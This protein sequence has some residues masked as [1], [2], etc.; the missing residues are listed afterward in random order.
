MFSIFIF[1]NFSS[2]VDRMN[3]F[4]HLDVL[5]SLDL[6]IFFLPLWLH[7]LRLFYWFKPQIAG[8]L[9]SSVLRTLVFYVSLI[10]QTTSSGLLTVIKD[11][12]YVYIYILILYP[13]LQSYT[14]VHCQFDP[15]FLDV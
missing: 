2:A 11:Y 13:D 7:F 10:A 12:F 9:K 3:P 15:V 14:Y 4:S 1:L 5:F 6:L 8:G